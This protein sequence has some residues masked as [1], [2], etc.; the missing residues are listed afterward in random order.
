MTNLTTNPYGVEARHASSIDLVDGDCPLSFTRSD[1]VRYAGPDQII[2][3]ALMFQMF[4]RAF[5]ELKSDHL[6]DRSNVKMQVGFP[7]P[8]VL[9]CIE[10]VLRGRTTN[11]ANISIKTE[12]LPMEAPEALVGRFYFE[13]SYDGKRIALWPTE[14]YITEEFRSM[15][16]QFQPRKGSLEDQARYQAFKHTMVATLMATNPKE[17]FKVLHM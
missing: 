7:G 17:L 10:L 2:A 13:F 14:T 3:T 9:D 12:D 4:T 1:L 8:G 11:Q 6:I 15:V 5:D 16:K